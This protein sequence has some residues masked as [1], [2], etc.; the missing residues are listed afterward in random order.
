[1][2]A[3]LVTAGLTTWSTPAQAYTNPLDCNGGP[4]TVDCLLTNGGVSEVWYINDVHYDAGDGQDSIW[5][6]CQ[7]STWV[8]IYVEYTGGDGYGSAATSVYCGFE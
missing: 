4:K 3:G 2:L 6:H 7:E 1:M 8:G 5:A